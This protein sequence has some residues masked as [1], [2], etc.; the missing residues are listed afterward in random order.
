M[1]VSVC[2][3]GHKL[4]AISCRYRA[5]DLDTKIPSLVPKASLVWIG[6]IRQQSSTGTYVER[7]EA[8][9]QMR[10]QAW[11]RKETRLASL[12]TRRAG[13]PM[14]GQRKKAFRSWFDPLKNK[15]LFDER[16]SRRDGLP[17]KVQVAAIVERLPLVIWDKPQW[18]KDYE[19]LTT[20]LEFFGKEYPKELDWN[21]VPNEMDRPDVTEEELLA[22][23]PEGYSPAPRET[24]ADRI[25]DIRTLDRK[26]KTRVFLAVQENNKWAFPCAVAEENETL[27]DAAKRATAESVG[28]DLVLYCPSNCPMAVDTVVYSE[29]EQNKKENSGFIGQ[30]V[31]YFRIQR[32]EGDVEEHA[33]SVDDFAWLDKDEMTQK[34][35]EQKEE[36]LSTL[37]HYLL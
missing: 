28:T 8:A 35:K 26:L 6:Q 1:F 34:V 15:Q 5:A 2:R 29:E 12:K 25:G 36:N 3:R 19:E 33:M 37:F 32:H 23:L 20:Y 31:F 7:K 11:E 24:E 22:M 13:R 30:K 10:R 21:K 27:L 16:K 9:K 4:S 14:A 18:L 17:W